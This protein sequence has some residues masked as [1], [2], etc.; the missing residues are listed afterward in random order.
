MIELNYTLNKNYS[1]NRLPDTRT[2]CLNARLT[3]LRAKDINDTL[4][5]LLNVL[6]Q[7]QTHCFELLNELYQ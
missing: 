7:Y 1:I 3:D 2:E 4:F 6:Y 5:D